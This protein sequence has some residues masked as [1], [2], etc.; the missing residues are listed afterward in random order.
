MSLSWSSANYDY[1]FFKHVQRWK[2]RDT[3]THH[4]SKWVSGQV[5]VV[6]QCFAKLPQSVA[7]I[8]SSSGKSCE[9]LRLGS[10]VDVFDNISLS[11]R[12][13][14]VDGLWM[15]LSRLNQICILSFLR[16]SLGCSSEFCNVNAMQCHRGSQSSNHGMVIQVSRYDNS[17]VASPQ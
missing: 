2:R 7:S 8:Q 13:H 10:L 3:L 11:C 17:S 4:E 14:S 15:G 12:Q 6:V 9:I 5:G 16:Y 1:F